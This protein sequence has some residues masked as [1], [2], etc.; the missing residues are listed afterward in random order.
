[1]REAHSQPRQ[2]LP[3]TYLQNA[4]I[5]AL[6][7][8]TILEKRSMT[9]DRVFGY[10]MNSNFD[11]DTEAQFEQASKEISLLGLS[12]N[13]PRKTFCFDVDGV[14]ATLVEGNHYSLAQP[15]KEM[16]NAIN[17]LYEIGHKII[18][19]TA[20]GSA[21]GIDWTKIT[22]EQMTTWGV[23]YHELRFGKPAADYY[24]DDRMLDVA[25]VLH[26]AAQPVEK[27]DKE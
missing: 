6:R 2:A 7:P 8:R 13:M 1:M 11:I 17:Q 3:E 12:I 18:L 26:L 24:I 5:D 23:K 15:R 16:I 21:T 10:I 22:Q 14:I 4:C 27:V 19:F 25:D 9:G 20:R